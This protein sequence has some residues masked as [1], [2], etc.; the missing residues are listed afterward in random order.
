[1]VAVVDVVVFMI[2]R[3]FFTVIPWGAK[4]PHGMLK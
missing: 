2:Q 1:M 3:F 4:I